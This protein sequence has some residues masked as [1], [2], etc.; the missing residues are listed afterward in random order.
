MKLTSIGTVGRIGNP[1]SFTFNIPQDRLPQGGQR[2]IAGPYDRYRCNPPYQNGMLG[3]VQSGAFNAPGSLVNAETDTFFGDFDFLSDISENEPTDYVT[4][5]DTTATG[6][7]EV[8]ITKKTYEWLT[9]FAEDTGVSD[10]VKESVNLALK[11]GISELKDFL[12]P[13]DVGKKIIN[14]ANGK[15]GVVSADPNNPGKFIIRYDD[16]TSEAYGNQKVLVQANP[17]KS[18]NNM[19]LIV[20]VIVAAAFLL[21]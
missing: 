10:V 13:Q 21:K 20:G 9:D 12:T 7:A 16:G 17:P 19:L 18:D 4:L 5:R 15:K 8:S 2:T 1:Y 3:S 6:T 11:R 14:P